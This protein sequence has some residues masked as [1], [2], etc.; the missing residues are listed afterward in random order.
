MGFFS[1]LF[2]TNKNRTLE[3]RED[4]SQSK[5]SGGFDLVG[6]LTGTGKYAKTNEEKEEIRLSRTL[7]V[8]LG[9]LVIKKYKDN[10]LPK[11]N[12]NK[13]RLEVGVDFNLRTLPNLIYSNARRNSIFR[14]KIGGRFSIQDRDALKMVMK[15]NSYAVRKMKQKLNQRNEN[16]CKVSLGMLF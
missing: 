11:Y 7:K 8:R 14:N 3:N 2:G 12:D 4:N 1:I 9:D 5:Q 13:H 6:G 15:H 16:R 10:R